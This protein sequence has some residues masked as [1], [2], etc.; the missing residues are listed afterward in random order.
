VAP[1]EPRPAADGGYQVEHAS[2]Q[3][4]ADRAALMQVRR[5]V[6]IEEQQVPENEEWDEH[7]EVCFHLLARSRKRDAVGTARLH[8]SGRVGRVAVLAEHR[9]HGVGLLLMTALLELA[10]QRQVRRLI[11]HSQVHAL[12]FYSKLGFMPCSEAFVEA[13][14]VHIEMQLDL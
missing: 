10:R 11:L 4:E 5:R 1:L 7:D 6:F 14:I 3:H 9:G 2:W 8:P 12:A 13:G